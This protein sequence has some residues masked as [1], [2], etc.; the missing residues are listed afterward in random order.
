[1]YGLVAPDISIYATDTSRNP[2]Y[3]GAAK[4]GLLQ[5]TRY[6]AAE[7]GLNG[8]RVNSIS[9][10]PFPQNPET[11]DPVFVSE[12]AQRT[13]VGRVGSPED[14]TTAVLFL[15]SPHSRFVTGSNVVVDGGWTVR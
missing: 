1:M 3:Y 12:L 13:L 15:A 7:F 14:L 5:L 6:A 2:P 11:M 9:P 8:V 4:A 10:G